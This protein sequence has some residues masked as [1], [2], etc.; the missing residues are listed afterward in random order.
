MLDKKVRIL[1]GISVLCFVV[2][3]LLFA[4]F[5]LLLVW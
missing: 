2:A 5:I 1:L 4:A 3:V